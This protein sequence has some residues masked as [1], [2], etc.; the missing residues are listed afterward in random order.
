MVHGF[1]SISITH[2]PLWLLSFVLLTRFRSFFFWL[3]VNHNCLICVHLQLVYHSAQ[4]SYTWSDFSRSPRVMMSETR[5]LFRF[6]LVLLSSTLM[7]QLHARLAI[8]LLFVFLVLI[9]SWRD[10]FQVRETD[11]SCVLYIICSQFITFEQITLYSAYC[12]WFVALL[13]P[14]YGV[15]LLTCPYLFLAQFD[16]SVY[17]RIQFELRW[18]LQS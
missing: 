9:F 16:S 4:L 5:I 12:A 8:F 17:I 1:D 11:A 6:I 10:L 13:A 15:L 2:F 7:K 14:P 18:P 3:R